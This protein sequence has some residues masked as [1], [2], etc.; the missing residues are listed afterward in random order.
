MLRPHKTTMCLIYYTL[1][2]LIKTTRH[3][4]AGFSVASYSLS[5]DSCA[6][7]FLRDFNLC[8]LRSDLY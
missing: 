3:L 1:K 5:D 4:T 6:I 7:Y 2:M 8:T